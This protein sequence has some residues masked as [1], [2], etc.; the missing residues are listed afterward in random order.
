MPT[1]QNSF[2]GKI[3]IIGGRWRGTV[4]P[5]TAQPALRPS[6]SRTRE[7]LFNWLG[8]RVREA[9]CLDLFAGSGALGIEAL[10]RGANKLVCVEQHR[11]TALQLR[12]QLDR[13]GASEYAHVVHANTHHWINHAEGCFDLCFLD[14]PFNDPHLDQCLARL[15]E[16]Q[17]IRT[18]GLIYLETPAHSEV[19][20]P[21]GWKLYKQS[22]QGM[23][24]SSLYTVSR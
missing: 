16:S 8:V 9:C 17:L 11:K 24:Q 20:I 12:Q 14:P 13:L 1:R 21:E 2:P 4:L 18:D 5:I 7:T 15:A 19:R 22:K 3:R 6:A 10:S 23:S